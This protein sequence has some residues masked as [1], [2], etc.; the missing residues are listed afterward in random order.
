MFAL[1]ESTGKCD[2]CDKE[3][4]QALLATD[5]FHSHTLNLCAGCISAFS[6]K[7]ASETIYTKSQ[8]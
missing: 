1:I 7:V 4:T 6:Q 3:A 2:V 5:K 8:I